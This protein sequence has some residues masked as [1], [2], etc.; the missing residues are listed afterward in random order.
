MPLPPNSLRSRAA[1]TAAAGL[2]VAVAAALGPAAAPARA[3]FFASEAL[4]GPS[5]DIEGLGGVDVARDG[6]GG[7]AYVKRDGGVDHIFV[8]RLAG[9]AWQAPERVDQGP[10][11]RRDTK[12]WS[13]PPSRLT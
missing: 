6:T 3:A 11:A 4:D 1:A 13:T 10:P 8:S 7:L 12:M 2:L 5:T 9:G